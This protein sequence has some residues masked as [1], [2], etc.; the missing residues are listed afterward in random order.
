MLF[1]LAYQAI[2]CYYQRDVA[3]LVAVN[4]TNVYKQRSGPMNA[5]KVQKDILYRFDI[6]LN[7]YSNGLSY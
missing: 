6:Y 7:R 4:Q 1:F 3:C 5:K 2:R